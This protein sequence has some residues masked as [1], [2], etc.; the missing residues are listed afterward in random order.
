M[1]LSRLL[2]MQ[3]PN[4]LPL[5]AADPFNLF[6]VANYVLPKVEPFQLLVCMQMRKI[7]LKL[8]C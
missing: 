3:I 6:T 8:A 7:A 4:S 1:H 5:D 2:L